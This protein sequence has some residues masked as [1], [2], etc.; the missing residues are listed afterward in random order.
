MWCCMK[1]LEC[2][3]N[4]KQN[5]KNKYNVLIWFDLDLFGL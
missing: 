1:E 2:N 3:Y 5:H 4:S